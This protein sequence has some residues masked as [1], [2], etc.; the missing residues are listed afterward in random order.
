VRIER[1]IRRRSWDVRSE[2]ERRPTYEVVRANASG[3]PVSEHQKGFALAADGSNG[4]A[5]LSAGQHFWVGA[6][7]AHRARPPRPDNS[8]MTPAAG[9]TRHRRK[10]CRTAGSDGT[11]VAKAHSKS[12]RPAID[13]V[14]RLRLDGRFLY[15]VIVDDS[16]PG[17]RKRPGFSLG[18]DVSDARKLRQELQQVAVEDYRAST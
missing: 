16:W 1:P 11:V 17:S 6:L 12:G 9:L 14:P 15:T 7:V 13:A 5:V 4:G 3:T 18:S 2:P 8:A 10:M